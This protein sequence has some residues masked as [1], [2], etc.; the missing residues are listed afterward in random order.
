MFCD[1][2]VGPRTDQVPDFLPIESASKGPKCLIAFRVDGSPK[3]ALPGERIS[4][5]TLQQ[6]ARTKYNS[7]VRAMRYY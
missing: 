4:Y 3:S 7:E 5:A 2:R 1:Y 6:A